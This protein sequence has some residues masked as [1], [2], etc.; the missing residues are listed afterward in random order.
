MQKLVSYGLG[1]P[2]VLAAL[3]NSNL[4]V[5]GQTIDF[6][7]QSA[8]VS[9]I[10]QVTALDHLRDTMVASTNGAPVLLSDIASIDVG[11]LPRL[12]IAGQDRED[13]IVEGIVL[14]NRD[15]QTKPMTA[16]V[17]AEVEKI[18][19]G[20][21]LPPGVHIEPIYD[22]ANLI[23]STTHTVLFNMVA[24]IL[25]VFLVQWLFFG[26]LRAAIIVAVTI[27][28]ALAFAGIIM[29]A[30]GEPANL[31]SFGAIDFGLVVAT[32]VIMMANIFRQLSLPPSQRFDHSVVLDRQRIPFELRGRFLVVAKSAFEVNKS[33]FFSAA[34]IIAGFLPLFALSGIEGHIFAPMARTYAYALVGG[35]LAT[36]TVTPALSAMFLRVRPEQAEP[37]IMRVLRRVYGPLLRQALANRILV[38]GLA[39][40]ALAFATVE[41]RTLGLEFMPKLEEG[42]FWIRATMPSSVGLE[43]TSEVV[44]QMRGVLLDYPEVQTVVSQHG[45][46]DDGTDATAFFNVEF[47]VPLTPSNSWPAG[48]TKA[49][50]T[51]AIADRLNAAFPGID[52][53]FSQNIADN[54]DEATSGVK[55]ENSIKL[56]GDDLDVLEKTATKIR[57]TMATI[58]GITDLGT[59]ASLGQPTL[60]VVVNCLRAA[61]YGLQPGDINATLQAAVG[62]QAAGSFYEPGT[63][64]SFPITVRL[65]PEYRSSIDAIRRITIA[66]PGPNGAG[67]VQVPLSDV[68][69]VRLVSGAGFIYREGEQRYIPIKFSVRGRDLAGAVAEAQK[70]VAQRV[71]L[72][73]GYHLEWAGAFGNLQNA[74]RRL[75]ILVP[76]AIFLILVLLFVNFY[77]VHDALLAASVIPMAMLGGVFALGLSGTPFSVSAAIG[78]IAMFGISAMDGIIIITFYNAKLQSG[79]DKRS[80]LVRACEAQMRPVLLTC[81]SACAGL[82]PAA[83]STGIGSQAQKPLALVVAGGLLLAPALILLVQP[84]LISLF[85]RHRELL[86]AYTGGDQALPNTDGSAPGTDEGQT[87]EFDTAFWHKLPYR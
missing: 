43:S 52:F 18:N 22:F 47:F 33:V 53:N 15:V 57:D 2:Q 83:F 14:V 81:A 85:S 38:V 42:N 1:L 67:V 78:F 11:N 55:G 20:D 86:A 40:V 16:A 63:D 17:E 64:H 49:S 35:L 65:S 39:G 34:I 29:V 28:F 50:L 26:N 60:Q 4:D 30:R 19:S 23:R 10:G 8:I 45:R 9:G 27:P 36:F 71:A 68:A 69:D 12:G 80:A 62:G 5:G 37:V 25:L 59:F 6:A 76:T 74:I 61:R 73:D 24:G 54:I 13:D 82:L 70:A 77:S 51:K 66:A 72:P 87:P 32:T 84:V 48:V 7:Q 75:T 41:V 79:F 56:F 3:N 46:P 44:N 58:P 31:L 21:V